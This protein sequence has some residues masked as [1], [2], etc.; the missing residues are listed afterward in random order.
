[1]NFNQ[2]FLMA[3]N[4]IR[5]TALGCQYQIPMPSSGSNADPTKINVQ[6]TPSGGSAQIIPE[7]T[8]MAHC[9][10][11]GDA[12]YYDNPTAPTQILLCGSTCTKVQADSN[13]KIE[14]LL[15]CKTIMTM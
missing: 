12:W 13:G 2:S 9:P 3:L 10:A 8:D 15:G 11:S 4:Q 14:I 7:V 5:G 6:Y 1:M